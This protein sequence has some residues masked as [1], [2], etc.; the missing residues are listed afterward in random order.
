MREQKDSKE[1]ILKMMNLYA[2]NQYIQKMLISKTK[3]LT[4]QKPGGNFEVVILEDFAN[5]VSLEDSKN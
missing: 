1:K 2:I 4:L 5:L 3:K